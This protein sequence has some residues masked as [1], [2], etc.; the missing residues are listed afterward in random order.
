MIETVRNM[1]E[2]YRQAAPAVEQLSAA[3]E[4]YEA[5]L[6][7]LKELFAWYS[8]PEWMK[9]YEADE[10]G[11]FPAGMPRGVLNEDCLYDLL[12]DHHRLLEQM[13]SLTKE[14]DHAIPKG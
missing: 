3:L 11:E 14:H 1:E 6:P 13:R 8:S 7:L 9:A 5:A 4:A 12:S 2:K 10:R